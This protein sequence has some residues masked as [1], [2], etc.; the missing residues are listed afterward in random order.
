MSFPED[1]FM[2]M[3]DN[4]I[5]ILRD[6]VEGEDRCVDASH[7]AAKAGA[8]AFQ[9][10]T[11]PLGIQDDGLGNILI[12]GQCKRCKTTIAI[13]ARMLTAEELKETEQ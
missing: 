4:T 10:A 13:M 8:D 9:A 5:E 3:H 2:K 11:V 6:W 7:R 1:K 12:M